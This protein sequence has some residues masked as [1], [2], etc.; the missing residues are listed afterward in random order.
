[1]D[2]WN[3]YSASKSIE[4]IKG[5]NIAEVG[6][7]RCKDIQKTEEDYGHNFQGWVYVSSAGNN[8]VIMV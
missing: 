4:N 7:H 2:N 6:F 1:M 3:N 8:I 5:K